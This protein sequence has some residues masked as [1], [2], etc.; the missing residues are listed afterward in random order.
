MQRLGPYADILVVNVSSPNTPGLRTLQQS[1]TLK[2]I[3][4]GVVH[5]A[6]SVDRT[7]KPA[8]MVKVSPDED[9]DDQ[10]AGICDAV[11]GS[12]VDGVIVGNTTHRRPEPLTQ[13]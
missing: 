1:D 3:L 12:G 4:T 10:I 6:K 9:S 11:W 7:T 13:F 8:V 5:A 2:P